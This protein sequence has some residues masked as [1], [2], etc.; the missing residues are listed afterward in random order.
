MNNE[1]IR[2]TPIRFVVC[3]LFTVRTVRTVT[4]DLLARF[5][6]RN[7]RYFRKKYCSL[8]ARFSQFEGPWLRIMTNQLFAMLEENNFAKTMLERVC[9]INDE[10]LVVKMPSSG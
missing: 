6:V 3:A 5:A 10:S 7:V 1:Q 9:V 8:R 2:R 4:S